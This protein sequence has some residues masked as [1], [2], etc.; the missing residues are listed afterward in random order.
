M[1]NYMAFLA[2]LLC[3]TTCLA[4]NTNINQTSASQQ[5][6]VIAGSSVGMFNNTPTNTQVANPSSAA[7]SVSEGGAGGNASGQY[8]NDWQ[9]K[10]DNQH[11]FNY[12]YPDPEIR[13]PVPGLPNLYSVIPRNDLQG[14]QIYG[15]HQNGGVEVIRWGPGDNG[16]YFIKRAKD[17]LGCGDLLHGGL[18][19]LAGNIGK[20]VLEGKNGYQAKGFNITNFPKGVGERPVGGGKLLPLIVINASKFSLPDEALYRSGYVWVGNLSVD[21]PIR[22]NE[23]VVDESVVKGVYY[24]LLKNTNVAICQLWYQAQPVTETETTYAPGLS[25]ASNDTHI[26]AN[27]GAGKLSAES[28]TSTKWPSL[29]RCWVYDPAAAAKHLAAPSIVDKLMAADGKKPVSP[30]ELLDAVDENTI[31][32]L[33]QQTTAPTSSVPKGSEKKAAANVSSRDRQWSPTLNEVVWSSTS[34]K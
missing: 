24:D 2:A 27:L 33:E 3:A 17:V 1:R 26:A 12:N 21:P 7:V 11:E 14:P 4:Q 18:F 31:Y 30:G 6:E 28:F 15:P 29:L 32:Y 16:T 20:S 13:T 22:Y 25:L 23:A 19:G 8:S 34:L 9:L 5:T 10:I